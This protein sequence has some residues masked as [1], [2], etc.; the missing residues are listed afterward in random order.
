MALV[1]VVDDETSI[2]EFLE[3]FLKRAGHTV[4]LAKDVPE[5][6]VRFKEEPAPDLVLTDLR[7]PRGSGLDVLQHVT[8]ANPA[9]QVVMMTAFATTE[10]AV[11][12]MRMGAYDYIIKPFK[13]D[14]LAVVIERALERRQLRNENRELKA[15]LDARAA[16]SRLL[17]TSPAMK[18][19]FDLINKV[20][21]T[22]TTVLLTGESGTGKELVSRGIHARGPRAQAPFVAINCGAIPETLIESELFGHTKGSFTGAHADRPG[23]FE[24]A[25]QGT[26][27]LDEIGELPLAM[28]VKLLRVLQERKLRRVGGAAD[29][30]VDCRVI[31]ATNRD[32]ELEIQQGRFREDLFFRLNVIQ[33][34][35]PALRERRE[36]IPMLVDA[37]IGKFAEQQQSAVRGTSREV[38]RALMAWHWP[39]NVRELENVIERGVTLASGELVDV[40]VLP[41]ALRSGAAMPAGNAVVAIVEEVPPEGL[42]LESVLEAYE[43]RLLERALVRT[44]G[45]KKKAAELLRVSFRSF[46]YR[47]A[48]LG[49]SGGDDDPSDEG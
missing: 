33:I 31:A 21:P 8:R 47:L 22:R 17:G 41:P 40:D 11:E 43:R 15:T 44:G 14:E 4:R 25:G 36:D 5:A 6:I 46:R 26:V 13:V 1:L 30:D 2:R 35:L 48:K 34:H 12:A 23:L 7:L 16:Y 49:L 42:D 32:L 28:Q 24:L 27:F 38:M 39:G 29:I 45:R 10:T 3:I 19:V 37:F 18:E 20:A 9:T